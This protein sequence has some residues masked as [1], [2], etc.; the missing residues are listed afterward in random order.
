MS[1]I[2]P[3]HLDNFSF[4]GISYKGFPPIFDKIRIL[5]LD[6]GASLKYSKP[7]GI[8]LN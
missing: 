1:T 7:I 4:L 5:G 8:N 3:Q 6:T 2:Y